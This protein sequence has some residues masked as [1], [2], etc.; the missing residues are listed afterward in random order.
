M[1]AHGTVMQV[2]AGRRGTRPA[3]AV[4]FTLLGDPG[5]EARIDAELAQI[6]EAARSALGGDLIALILVGGYAR[7][8]GAAER[9]YGQLAPHNDYDLLAVVPR[10]DAPAAF[11]ARQLSDAWSARLGLHVDVTPVPLSR[12]LRPP[13]TL[14]WLDASAGGARVLTGS[15]G[16]LEAMPRISPRAVPLEEASRLLMNRAVGLA[17]SRLRG[18]SEDPTVRARHVHKAMLACGD[19]ILLAANAYAGDLA[20]RR[21]A[22]ERLSPAPAVGREIVDRYEDAIAFR[23]DASG[24]APRGEESEVWWRRSLAFIG[25]RHLRFEAG[26]AGTPTTVS[27]FVEHRGALFPEMPD[28]RAGLAWLSAI[29]ARVAGAAALRPY[30]GHPRERLARVAA[31]LAYGG[32]MDRANAA[33]LLGAPPGVDDAALI[34]KLL[35][36]SARGS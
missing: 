10:V 30:L 1:E 23:R 15:R 12:V 7:G 16:V 35:A 25:E 29:R 11:A 19:A 32:D 2:F 28:A 13:P 5:L 27:A 22:L 31:A 24:A 33:T 9:R 36:L 21:R 4:R 34:D 17:L 20:G 14:F 26:R 8:E 6:A 3:T 18:A